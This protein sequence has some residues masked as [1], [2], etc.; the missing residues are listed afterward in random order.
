[1]KRETYLKIFALFVIFIY[2]FLFGSATPRGTLAGLI[3]D[4]GTNEPLAYCNVFLANTTIGD[5]A[6]NNGKF[7]LDKIPFGS[8]QLVVSHIGYETVVMDV[9]IL[10]GKVKSIDIAMNVKAIEGEEIHVI[11]NKNSRQWQCDL[12]EFRQ[13]F[14]GN[15]ENSTKC[16]ILNPEVISFRREPGTQNLLAFSDQVIVVEN[17][18]LGYKLDIVLHSFRW[19]RDGGQYIIYPKYAELEP[20]NEGEYKKWR[21]NRAETF[22]LS[23][24]DFFASLAVDDLVT[25]YKLFQVTEG[26]QGRVNNPVSVD[27]LHIV[28]IDSTWGLRRIQLPGLFRVESRGGMSNLT[29]KYDYLDFDKWGNIFPANGLSVSGYWGQFRVADAL[30]FDYRPDQPL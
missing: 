10:P 23:M 28:T 20:K 13:N 17:R 16:R 25:Q 2:S 4:V 7:V 9:A 24:R 30:P 22:R 11:A 3:R 18:S 12:K 6:D 21:V 19:G 26:M 15:T 8:Y 27:S 1:M 14:I 29:L 5:A